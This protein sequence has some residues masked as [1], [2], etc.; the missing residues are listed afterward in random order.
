MYLDL[1]GETFAIQSRSDENLWKSQ[2]P[3]SLD[4]LEN[5]LLDNVSHFLL[6]LFTLVDLLLQISDLLRYGIK[7]M[8]IRGSIGDGTNER[9]IGVFKGLPAD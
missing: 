3:S 8:T 2:W 6:L 7:T 9:S 5:V 4:L 1:S